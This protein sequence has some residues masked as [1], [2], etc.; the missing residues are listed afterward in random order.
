[1]GDS[2]GQQSPARR[3]VQAVGGQIRHANHLLPGL[4]LTALVA[5]AGL[6]ASVWLGERVLGFEKSPIS[7]IMMAIL[8]GLALGNLIRLPEAVL[9]GVKFSVKTVLRLG[10]ILLGIRLGLGDVLRLGALGIPLIVLCIS[11]AI[12]FTR[13]L[14]RRLALPERM[15]TLIAVG[16]S[17]C[18]A[19]AIVATGP[20]IGAEDEEITYAVANITVFG[21]LAMF[22]YPYLAH[23]LFPDNPVYAGLFLGT[24]IHETA[25]VAGSGLI[26][27][28]LFG[29]PVGLDT[30]TITKLVRNVF[31]AGIIP[32]MAVL[33]R[34]RDGID[35]AE[36]VSV[37]SLFPVFILGF[38]ALALARTVGDA[39]VD[40]GG[41]AFGLWDAA[42]WAALVDTLKMWAENFLAMAMAG[43]GLGTRFAQIRALGMKPFYAGLGAAVVVGA[44]SL[45]GI[46]ILGALGLG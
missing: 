44:L 25:Q 37:L 40:G 24:S 4:I 41:R 35:G 12:L 29:A 26:Y 15:A 5:W 30:A 18:G 36:R 38:V 2:T 7:G 32:L 19:T 13:W 6:W 34:R 33:Y 1:M 45:A 10:I 16:T 8:I 27:A 21:L 31:M 3:R 9:P 22:L 11:G 42:G 46:A 14:G 23:A 28:D 43:V 39:L 20:A 17:I